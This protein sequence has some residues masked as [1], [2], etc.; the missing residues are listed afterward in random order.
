[1]NTI[2][3]YRSASK[4]GCAQS[5]STAKRHYGSEIKKCSILLASTSISLQAIPLGPIC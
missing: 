3:Q 1:M 5:K 4:T 2:K